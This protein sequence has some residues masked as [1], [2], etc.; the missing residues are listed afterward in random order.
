LNERSGLLGVSGRSADMREIQRARGEGDRA[1]KLAFDLFVH[2]AR[3]HLAGMVASLCG[4]DALVFSGGIGENSAE[5]REAICSG[6]D[7]CGIALERGRNA[8]LAG[9]G[10]ISPPGARVLVQ[11]VAPDEELAIARATLAHLAES[12]ASKGP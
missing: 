3:K 7:F 11:V 4:I 1:A 5:V 6:L 9:E 10:A 12:L 2:R 8:A